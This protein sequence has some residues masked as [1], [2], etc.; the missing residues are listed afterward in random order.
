MKYIFHKKVCICICIVLGGVVLDPVLHDTSVSYVLS[1]IFPIEIFT[2]HYIQ[3]RT[4]FNELVL[5]GLHLCFIILLCLG[6]FRRNRI[7]PIPLI[8]NIIHSALQM[9]FCDLGLSVDRTGLVICNLCRR[10]YFRETRYLNYV[11]MRKSKR[12]SLPRWN[13]IKTHLMSHKSI[14]ESG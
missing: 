14:K 12:R 3:Y 2:T 13:K 7:Q 8:L 10:I 5:V 1:F 9:L 6:R 4:Q 11:I